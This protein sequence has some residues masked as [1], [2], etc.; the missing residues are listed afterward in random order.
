MLTEAARVLVE[1]TEVVLADLEKAEAAVAELASTVGGTLALAAFPTAARALAPGAIALC[2][3]AHPGL[4]VTLAELPT[5]EALDAVKAGTIDIALSYGYNL[6]P[7]Q[8]DAGI[9]VVPLLTEP[10]LAALPA[11]FRD[12]GSP[13]ALAELT[14]PRLTRTVSAAIRAGSAKQPSI[15]AMLAALR[16]TAAERHRYA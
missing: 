1:H 13:I 6:L 8:R 14:E 5:P 9:E 10:L 7:R 15:E 4:R 3:N 16:T 2:G 11:G 12:R